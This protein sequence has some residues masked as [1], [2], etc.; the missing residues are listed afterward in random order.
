MMTLKL[1]ADERIALNCLE[2]NPPG[3]DLVMLCCLD[4]RRSENIDLLLKFIGKFNRDVR[5][6][7]SCGII[8]K[9]GS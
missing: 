6:S 8:I 7:R 3:V 2:R 9:Q 1:T 5:N 4:R